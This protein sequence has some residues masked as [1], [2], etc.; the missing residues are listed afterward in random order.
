MYSF[1]METTLPEGNDF[2]TH[3]QARAH[4]QEILRRNVV[5]AASH[6]LINGGPEALTVRRV[7][8]KLNCSTKIIYTMF[9]GKD[10][11]ANALYLEGCARLSQAIE[12]VPQVSTPRAYIQAITQAYWD[13]ALANPSYYAVLFGGAIPRFQPSKTSKQVMT[14]AFETVVG[15]LQEYMTQGLLPVQDAELLTKAIW[16]P[17]H[18]VVSLYILDHFSSLEEAQQTFERTRQTLVALLESPAA[19]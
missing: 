12:K 14:A 3:Q 19:L 2:T 5:E 11:L 9:Q 4:G 17:L 6:L 10:G 18:G 1:L 16:A 13:F 8:Q 15:K 7:A